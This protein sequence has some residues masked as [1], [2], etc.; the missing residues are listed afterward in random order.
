MHIYVLSYLCWPKTIGIASDKSMQSPGKVTVS[1]AEIIMCDALMALGNEESTSYLLDFRT[2]HVKGGSRSSHLFFTIKATCHGCAWFGKD[3]QVCMQA[4]SAR[5]VSC[6]WAANMPS[7][8]QNRGP[9]SNMF[10]P[11]LESDSCIWIRD[12]WVKYL[13]WGNSA[14]KTVLF[15]LWLATISCPQTYPI[16]DLLLFPQLSRD[17][18]Q[19]RVWPSLCPQ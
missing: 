2:T 15:S 16:D 14:P 11:V 13:F 1:H 7:I 19:L 5:D 9:K 12:A 4:I 10:L 8:C 3:T 6:K 18:F 17:Q